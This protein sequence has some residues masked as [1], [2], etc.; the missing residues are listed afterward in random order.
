MAPQDGSDSKEL[1]WEFQICSLGFH[2]SREAD[3]AGVESQ[4]FEVAAR[5]CQ[6]VGFSYVKIV[7][8]GVQS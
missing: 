7:G 6:G 5:V 1:C 3:C 2:A 8:A 4:Y